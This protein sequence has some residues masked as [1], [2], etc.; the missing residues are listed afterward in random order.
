[1]VGLVWFLRSLHVAVGF[2]VID[3]LFSLAVGVC[4]GHSFL[5]LA[6]C[7]GFSVSAC[8]STNFFSRSD[9]VAI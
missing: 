1:M 5:F 3:A 6:L 9:R 4:P 2:R 8:M 7:A